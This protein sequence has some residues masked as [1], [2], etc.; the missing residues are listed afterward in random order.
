M[1][2]QSPS[3]MQL[4]RPSGRPITA[5]RADITHAARVYEEAIMGIIYVPWGFC[6]V[7]Q[8]QGHE[9]DQDGNRHTPRASKN[10]FV[11]CTPPRTPAS[12]PNIIKPWK[13][14]LE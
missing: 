14:R 6:V 13:L 1:T 5:T 4:R 11:V 2:R 9:N 3:I 12:Y 7:S 10:G 8:H